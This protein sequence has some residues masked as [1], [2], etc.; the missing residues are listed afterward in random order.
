MS[1]KIYWTGDSTVKQN[2]FTT[3]PQ[4]GI[5]Q[6]M[7]LFIKPEAAILNHAENGRSTKSFIEETRLAA[8]Y[9]EMTAGDFLFIQFGHNDSKAEDP[10][11]YA[12]AWSEY[13]ANLE[14][15]VNAARNRKANPVFLTP[16][17]RRWF[18]EN[19]QLKERIHGDYPEAMFAS[20]RELGV[21]CIDLYGR[22][23]EL[24]ERQGPE[25]S[26]RYFMHLEPG[27]YPNYPEGLTD[28]TH[29]RYEGAVAFAELIAK[30]LKELGGIY[31]DL[32]LYPEKL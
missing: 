28:D 5:G 1:V 26:K 22:S 16:L 18:D 31:E 20:A 13:R 11:R 15:F 14:C 9:N 2:D 30:E 10:N 3:Y 8:I 24:I 23:R 19:N 6:G 25:A 7:R 12:E 27:E 29:L 4:T 32:L 21:A 17:C